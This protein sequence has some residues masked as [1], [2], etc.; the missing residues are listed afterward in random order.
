MGDD[1]RPPAPEM[2]GSRVGPESPRSGRHCISPGRRLPMPWA[3]R[4]GPFRATRAARRSRSLIDAFPLV[5]IYLG[6]E[7]PGGR[8]GVARGA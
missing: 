5:W 6:Q 4:F 3:D 1:A 8:A 7:A 2:T